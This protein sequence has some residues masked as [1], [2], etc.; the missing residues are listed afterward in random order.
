[1]VTCFFCDKE[2]KLSILLQLL[3]IKT[4]LTYETCDLKLYS[5]III[6]LLHKKIEKVEIFKQCERLITK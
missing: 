3:N 5:Q 1:M 4:K 2:Q 6:S